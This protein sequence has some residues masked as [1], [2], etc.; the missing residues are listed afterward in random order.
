MAKAALPVGAGTLDAIA[1]VSAGRR[2]LPGWPYALTPDDWQSDGRAILAVR[3]GAAG[4]ADGLRLAARIT[5]RAEWL[6]ARYG[7]LASENRFAAAGLDL[8]GTWRHAAGELRLELGGQEEGARASGFAGTLAR[9]GL[10]A[11]ASEELRLAGE[12]VRVG[13]AIRVER[14]GPFG[15]VSGKLGAS[16]KV[17]GP[18][19]LRASAGRTF[20]P[21]SDSEIHV[22]QG[23][24]QANPDLAPE[25]GLGGDAA[26]VLD[27][28]P[29][30][31]TLGA[32][33]TLY[34]DLV[35]Y[36]RISQG[37]LKPFNADKA[38]VRGLEL[39]LATVRL[40][41]PLGLSLSTAYTLLGT[42]I[43]RGGEGTLGNE[44]PHRAR[45]R[46]YARAGVAPG[47]AEAH[48]ELHY[49]GRQWADDH[50]L[51][52][53]PAALVWNAGAGVALRRD[54]AL[55]LAVELKNLLDD[56]ALQ[57]AYGNPLPG[58]TVW[59]TLSAGSASTKGT[60]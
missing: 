49:V 56:R 14:D 38:L 19:A 47:P 3:L 60:P 28:G 16:W 41:R 42:E 2:E 34:R 15:G 43:L 20:R 37:R 33:A 39:E 32:H 23:L 53:I 9:G 21:P 40:L 24:V 29:V 51:N 7:S 1:L 44:I 55:R 31:A 4:P 6:D 52:E 57:D 35:Y 48:V 50:N 12:R 27:G 45:H 11:A 54:P 46:L 13:T 36:Q 25:V 10:H 59:I 30:L 5:S 26:L 18:I 8:D 17:V 22:Q 58:R